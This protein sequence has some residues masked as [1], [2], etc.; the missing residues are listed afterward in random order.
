MTEPDYDV[1]I[2]GGGP[3]GVIAAIGIAREGYSCIIL[4]KK[5]KNKI[6]DKNCGDA[7][8]SLHTG[9]LEDEMGISPPSLEAG[10]ARELI[11]TITI[12]AKNLT[13]KLSATTPAYQV[14]R[15]VYGQRLLRIAEEEGVEIRGNSPVRGVIIEEDQIKGV[16][17]YNEDRQLTEL[18]SHITIDASG[19]IGTIRKEIPE[20][21]RFGVSFEFPDKYTVGTYREIIKLKNG[22]DHNFRNEIVLLYHNDIPPPGYAWIFTEGEAMLNIGITWV[23]SI[24]YPNDKS[25]KK[26]Y[27]EV[28]DPYI[29]PSTYEVVYKGG[30]NI[31]GMPNFD[32]L[33]VNGAMLVGDA[34][35]LAD[36]TT[37]E[38]HGPALESGRLAANAAVEALNKGSFRAEDL[39][40]YNKNLMAYPGGMHAQS[41]LISRF[42]KEMGVDTFS[43]LLGRELLT[44]ADLIEIFQEEK[45][46]G[47]AMK[48]KIF[49]KSFPKWGLMLRLSRKL[50]QIEKTREIYQS[51]PDNPKDLDSWRKQ[52][53]EIMGYTF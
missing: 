32:T 4:D 38:G 12:A 40:S 41:F 8:D 16:T 45:E 29:D 31:P 21:M 51:Y 50:T 15:L 14:D 28:L 11:E 24:D 9:I 27:H 35:G 34:G 3:A 36:P 48:L 1:I 22:N 53:N 37:F 25:M 46:V 19:Y 49:L 20:K 17:F 30:G 44:E 18:R 39:W 23:K 42:I 43:F 6:G 5:P 2:V 26:I 52:R 47:L 13:T 7:L 10:E 33:V